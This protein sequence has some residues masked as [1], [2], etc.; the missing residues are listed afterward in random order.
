MSRFP[1]RL[2]DEL[3]DG[4]NRRL[5]ERAGSD[6]PPARLVATAIATATRG[7]QADGRAGEGAAA[8]DS[9][10]SSSR[11]GIGRNQL[12]ALAGALL[13][14]GMLV[15][16]GANDHPSTATRVPTAPTLSIGD[17][18]SAPAPNPA[19]DNTSV[20]VPATSVARAPLSPS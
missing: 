13:V 7:A 10:S 15:W 1:R 6:E 8:S 14:G 4:P 5:L 12:V 19:A 2:L 17:R 16:V 9:A 3:E 20:N 11:R 18:P